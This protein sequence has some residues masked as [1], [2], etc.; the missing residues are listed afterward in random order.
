MYVLQQLEV[1]DLLER[2]YTAAEAESDELL[3]AENARLVTTTVIT[4]IGGLSE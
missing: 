1:C 4:L 2:M 3:Y